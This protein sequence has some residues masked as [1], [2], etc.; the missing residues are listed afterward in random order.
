[1]PFNSVSV[2]R[3][4]CCVHYGE[5]AENFI[6]LK[7]APQISCKISDILHVC[8]KGC[9]A[10]VTMQFIVLISWRTAHT[11]TYHPHFHHLCEDIRYLKY[12][13]IH[14]LIFVC[15]LD[16]VVDQEVYK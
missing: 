5:T 12:K 6:Y 11:P 8:V 4:P 1:M 3:S 2:S 14:F 9:F 10:A 7:G 15:L 16:L 13:F